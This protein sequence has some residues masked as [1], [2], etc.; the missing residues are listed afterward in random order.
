MNWKLKAALGATS[1]LLATQAAAQITFYEH[2]GF[3]GRAFTTD[4][5]V[6]NF[7]QQG[8][9]DLASSVVVDRGNWEVCTDARFEGRCVVLRRG[10]YESLSGLGLNDQISS[11]RPVTQQARY[12]N[13]APAPLAAPNYDYRVRAN[14]RVFEAPVTSVHAVMGEPEQ[15]CWVERQQVTEGG[16]GDANVGG[17][18]LGGIIGGV[19]GHQVGGGRGK[20]VATAGGAVAGALIGGN[21]GRGNGV[22]YDKD[23][24]RCRTVA[25]GTPAYWDVTYNYRGVE[26]RMQMSAPPGNTIAV[27]RNGE[28]RQ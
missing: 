11:V 3:R 16:R 9:N 17:A 24:Q 21:S 1:V 4:R 25:S 2:D 6:A 18:V 12:D 23:V 27:N 14:E 20:D 19:L 28:P 26:H 7:S 8:F 22:T 5:Q 13:E 10:S 15:R